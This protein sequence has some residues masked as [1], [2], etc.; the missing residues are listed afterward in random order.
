MNHN[1]TIGLPAGYRDVLFEEARAQ[2]QIEQHFAGVLEQ[3]GYRELTPSGV[4]FLDVYSRGLQ[5]VKDVTFK[6]LDR[7]DNLLALRADF[8]PAIARIAAA[9]ALGDQIPYRIWYAG[10]VFRKA[11]LNRGRFHEFRQ[12][13]AELIGTNSIDRDVEM[14]TMA[15]ECLESAGINDVQLHVNHAGV[16]RGIIGGLGLEGD[17]LKRITTYIDRKDMRRL[18]AS[19][20]HQGIAA[21]LQSQVNAVCRCVGDESMLRKTRD[22]V[23]NEESRK[24]MEELMLLAGKLERWRDRIIFDLTEIDELEYYTGVMFALFNPRLTSELGKGGR[25]DSLMQEFGRPM[26]AIGFSC[27]LDRLAELL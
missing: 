19:L 23:A 22:A 11:D 8:T 7:D 10:S 17:E 3:K 1:N 26:P 27:S 24:A 25:Y 13:G 12:I 6:F 14:M 5:S 9:G 2:R 16:F 18:E 20:D 15:M 4:E 21:D